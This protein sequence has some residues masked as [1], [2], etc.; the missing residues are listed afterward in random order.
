[1]NERLNCPEKYVVKA[2]IMDQMKEQ[3]EYFSLVGYLKHLKQ[4]NLNAEIL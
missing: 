1:M 4:C 2:S 3:K